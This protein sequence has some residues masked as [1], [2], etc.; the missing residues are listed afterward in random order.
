[1]ARP[2]ERLTQQS[3]QLG[4]GLEARSGAAAASA[5]S[6]EGRSNICLVRRQ[7]DGSSRRECSYLAPASSHGDQAGY[8]DK[9]A[10]CLPSVCRQHAPGQAPRPASAMCPR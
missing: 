3:A 5:L 8:V 2:N 10:P 1:M 7:S 6:A 9:A 4:R